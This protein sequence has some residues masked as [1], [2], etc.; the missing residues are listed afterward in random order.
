MADDKADDIAETTNNGPELS[1]YLPHVTFEAIPIKDLVTDVAYQRQLSEKPIRRTAANF[2][3]YQINLVKVS[4]RDGINYVFNG[5]HT[6]E[7]VATVSGSRDTPVWCMVY[8]DL[9]YKREANIFANQQK[10]AKKLTPYEI[11]VANMES[12]NDEQLLINE[13]VESYSLHISGVSNPGCICAVGALEKIYEDMGYEI[14]SR[15]LRLIVGIW[16]GEKQSLGSNIIKGM[17]KLLDC[18]STK[19]VDDIFIEKLETVS[20][21]EIIRSAKERKGRVIG[22]AEAML[23]VYNRKSR[24]PLF[25]DMNAHDCSIT[26]IRADN[27]NL[28]INRAATWL[29]EQSRQYYLPEHGRLTEKQIA[30]LEEIGYTWNNEPKCSWYTGYEELLRY[31]QKYG[32]VAVPVKYK[33]RIICVGGYTIGKN[34]KKSSELNE[35]RKS[36]LLAAISDISGNIQLM[37][38]KVSIIM[39]AQGVIIA[40]LL[41]I[42]D[43]LAKVAKYYDSVL[44]KS[45]CVITVLG[46]FI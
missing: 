13:L 33:T 39:A 7:V 31:K 4:R 17:A 37:D 14:L 8:D 10:Y 22:Y 44:E 21:Q 24:S 28:L 9:V 40:G 6:M 45:V 11:F 35:V 15:T 42:Y 12:G 34:K 18:Y 20:A 1:D 41:S 46:F 36:Y 30:L 38:T 23:A 3:A 32:N 43:N 26:D 19:I 5:Q 29:R 27:Q 2:D 16:E 25:I